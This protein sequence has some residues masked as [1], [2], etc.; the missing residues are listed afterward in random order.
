MYKAQGKLQEAATMFQKS[1]GI[2]IKALGEEHPS[3]AITLTNMGTLFKS[4]GDRAAAKD[5]WSR[6]LRIFREKL[7]NEHPNTKTVSRFLSEL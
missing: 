4:M 2:L 3:V 6:A 5:H 1:L 7:G